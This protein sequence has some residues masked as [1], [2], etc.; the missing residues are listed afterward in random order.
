MLL[1]S[2]LKC[3]VRAHFLI[4]FVQLESRTLYNI[5]KRV[6]TQFEDLEELMLRSEKVKL[7]FVLIKNIQSSLQLADLLIIAGLASINKSEPFSL[8]M[9][10]N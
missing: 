1:F 3:Y 7:I 9:L 5:L 2:F 10:P 6:L 4:L 8:K